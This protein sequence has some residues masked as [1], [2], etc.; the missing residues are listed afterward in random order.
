MCATF[1]DLTVVHLIQLFK[2]KGLILCKHCLLVDLHALWLVNVKQYWKIA[3]LQYW[4]HTS[5]QLRACFYSAADTNCLCKAL[6]VTQKTTHNTQKTMLQMLTSRSL[7]SKQHRSWDNHSNVGNSMV[8]M[9]W[10]MGSNACSGLIS[11]HESATKSIQ[12]ILWQCSL[13]TQVATESSSGWSC[14]SETYCYYAHIVC[15]VHLHSL[16]YLQ[17]KHKQLSAVHCGLAARRYVY[18]WSTTISILQKQL[19]VVVPHHKQL[20]L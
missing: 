4:Q 18:Y 15:C 17:C 8:V 5:I 13:D 6:T 12:A 3:V 2:F 7:S 10:G 1:T 9:N 19:L 14:C 20:L 16:I 11:S